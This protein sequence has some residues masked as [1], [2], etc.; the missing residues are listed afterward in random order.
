MDFLLRTEFPAVQTAREEIDILIND[1]SVRLSTLGIDAI[2][3]E[4]SNVTAKFDTKSFELRVGCDNITTNENSATFVTGDTLTIVGRTFLGTYFQNAFEQVPQALHRI[5]DVHHALILLH[6]A[7]Y[8]I[9][10][11]LLQRSKDN[12]NDDTPSNPNFQN[13]FQNLNNGEFGVNQEPSH[14]LKMADDVISSKGNDTVVGDSAVL[15]VQ[16][17]S[18][19]DT[20]DFSEVPK[21]V[22]EDLIPIL[23]KILK[24]GRMR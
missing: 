22:T 7:L 16:I 4:Q 18:V 10:L 14:R 19:H 3:A 2:H 8:E 23:A 9:H 15:F 13:S 12:T 11:D 20:F 21:N 17:D 5:Q 24:K 6:I 1:L